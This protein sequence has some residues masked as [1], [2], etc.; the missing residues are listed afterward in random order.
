MRV[1]IISNI[2]AP[3]RSEL[4]EHAARELE[5]VKVYFQAFVEKNRNWDEFPSLPY[6][7]EYLPRRGFQLG[8]RYVGFY[9]DVGHR[10]QADRPDVVVAYGFSTAAIACAGFCKK[11]GIPLVIA[12]DGTLDTDP[13]HGPEG[14]YRRWLVRQCQGYIAASSRAAEYFR[15]LGADGQ[16]IAV[17]PL[18]CDLVAIAASVANLRTADR[19]IDVRP[20]AGPVVCFPTRLIRSKRIRDACAAV[21]R[22]AKQLPGIRLKI[23]GDG[24]LKAELQDW[25]STRGES[26][27]ELLGMLSWPQMLE[28]YATSDLLLFTGTRERFGIVILEALAAGMPV[29]SY[30]RAGAAEFVQDGVNGYRVDEGDVAGLAASIQKVVSSRAH[31]SQLQRNA[32][33]VVSEHDVRI[34]ASQF[35]RALRASIERSPKPSREH[36]NTVR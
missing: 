26:R 24:P 13:L 22:A 10:L 23:A 17:I 18:S 31:Y 21:V 1:A 14:W 8:E 29:V 4:F 7:H 27:V 20:D 16:R 12:N 15:A 11:Q 30:S 19:G 33:R 9:T 25:L 2:T 3:Y 5:Y 28:M 35:T 34:K 6:P 32:A 36:A